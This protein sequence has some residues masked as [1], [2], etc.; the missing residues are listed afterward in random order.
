MSKQL[1]EATDHWHFSR[2]R[3]KNVLA[4]FI[5]LIDIIVYSCDSYETWYSK[6]LLPGEQ[7]INVTSP[8]SASGTYNSSAGPASVTSA[9]FAP[10][11][12]HPS[13]WEAALHSTNTWFEMQSLQHHHSQVWWWFLIIFLILFQSH[14]LQV[15]FMLEYLWLDWVSTHWVNNW[16]YA[17]WKIS[18]ILVKI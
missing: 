8:S 10:A 3:V 13:P 18:W 7:N 11:Y 4:N 17:S 9:S 15:H 2:N 12:H 6:T 16:L 1:S 14:Q 5:F